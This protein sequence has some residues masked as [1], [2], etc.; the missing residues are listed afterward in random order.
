MRPPLANSPA[1]NF[2]YL[3]QVR[4][5]AWQGEYTTTTSERDMIE[6]YLVAEGLLTWE[7]ISDLDDTLTARLLGAGQL[8]SQRPFSQSYRPEILWLWSAGVVI[9][10]EW[11]NN[12]N[13]AHAIRK[14]AQTLLENLTAIADLLR[15]ALITTGSSLSDQETR[16]YWNTKLLARLNWEGDRVRD[17]LF[18]PQINRQDAILATSGTRVNGSDTISPLE[19]LQIMAILRHS[20]SN[21]AEV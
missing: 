14:D 7:F 15:A 2:E 12:P 11:F 21:Q 3:P 19:L 13:D 10:Q 9:P 16:D 5:K 1:I 20:F 6:K 8:P 4:Q 18:G 17:P